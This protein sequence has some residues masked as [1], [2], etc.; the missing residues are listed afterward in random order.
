MRTGA[1]AKKKRMA[2]GDLFVRQ[3]TKELV[4]VM[5]ASKEHRTFGD[6]LGIITIRPFT[7]DPDGTPLYT[8][9]GSST[10]DT[11]MLE[12]E[13]VYVRPSDIIVTQGELA[14]ATGL[15]VAVNVDRILSRAADFKTPVDMYLDNNAEDDTNNL[16]GI[17]ATIPMFTDELPLIEQAMVD[18]GNKIEPSPIVHPEI[19]GRGVE[20][21]HGRAAFFYANRCKGKLSEME[22]LV[23]L[24]YG[25]K[26][27]PQELAAKYERRTNDYQRSYRCGVL[28]KDLEKMRKEIKTHRNMM[29]Y[30]QTFIKSEGSDD[31]TDG[32]MF[33]RR[34]LGL[35]LPQKIVDLAETPPSTVAEA[36]LYYSLTSCRTAFTDHVNV[37]KEVRLRNINRRLR[38]CESQLAALTPYDLFLRR[39]RRLSLAL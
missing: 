25:V 13:C 33:D 4:R 22:G 1:K 21:A 20:Y 5:K 24:A 10:H 11:T 27:I 3:D 15:T 8:L 23:H 32:H 12:R 19:A 37:T 34:T 26:N 35:I 18:F 38:R 36:G 28:S 6:M 17:L 39:S 29:D 31:K 9:R 2:R 30:H 7:R 14:K 16:Q